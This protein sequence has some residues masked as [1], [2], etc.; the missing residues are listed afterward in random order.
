MHHLDA[1]SPPVTDPAADMKETSY[2]PLSGGDSSPN[3]QRRQ[4]VSWKL[5][6]LIAAHLALVVLHA[7]LLLLVEHPISIPMWKGVS[8][9]P[10]KYQTPA[11]FIFA[12]FGT[13]CALFASHI[14]ASKTSHSSYISR[15]CSCSLSASLFVVMCSNGRL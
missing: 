8:L 6:G 9:D 12:V 7:A 14:L 13:V 5:V 4:W 11:T 10:D 3:L 2:E 1:A 15:F